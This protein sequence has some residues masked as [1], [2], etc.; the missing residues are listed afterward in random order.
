MWRLLNR[1]SIRTKF[2]AG[3]AL[4]FVW[5][6][7]LGGFAVDRLNAVEHAAAELRDGALQATVALSRIGQAAERLR[8]VQELLVT[9]VAEERRNTLMADHA[10]RA[11]D[12]QAAIELY[13]PTVTDGEE[14]GLAD[15]LVATW[16]AYGKLS[17]QLVAMTGQVQPDI[18]TGLL[19][20]RMLQAM[21]QFRDAQ[22]AAIDVGMATG[23]QAADRG[24][25]LG[26]VARRWILAAL[27]VSLAMCLCG[28]WLIIGDMARPIAAM[29]TA[30]RRLAQHDTNAAVVG[31]GRGDEIGMMADSV[32]QFRR[33]I[34][35][36]DRVAAERAAEQLA[37]A[38]H[39]EALET[40]VHGFEQQ[41]GELAGHLA[42]AA[43]T[44]QTTAG[45][46]SRSVGEASRETAS[47][48]A[49]AEQAR[50]N[51][52]AVAD[53]TDTLA[54]AIAEIGRQGTESA[55]IAGQAVADVQRTDRVVQALAAAARKIDEVLKLI[56][57]IAAQTNLLALN[58]TIEA[59]RAG[60]A[61]KGF[62]VVAS[63]VKS[64]AGQTARATEEIAGQVRQIQHTTAETVAA[65]QGIG[66]VVE[67]VGAIAASIAAAVEEQSAAT[68][69]IARNV[70]QAASG[71]SEVSA[72]IDQVSRT[73]ATAGASAEQVLA[74]ASQ[75]AGQADAL[76]EEMGQFGARFRAA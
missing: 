73:A 60:E 21:N 34:I 15:R 61:G 63:E 49:A 10:T 39:A 69:E 4:A 28:G 70:Q 25:A 72:S 41:I 56:G 66:A 19:N 75:V 9:A 7:G 62:A 11:K 58:A 76:S 30:M 71:T 47:V 35:E 54:S 2:I 26:R 43:C 24:E 68:V 31:L 17:S 40:L 37:K 48:A 46:M 22:H 50:A 8:S 3:F 52:Q 20:G 42:G 36:A 55:R 13:L 38:G 59:A 18:Q 53:A 12:V 51:V 16:A 33:G 67:H 23:R 5:T 44:L 27:G 32:E 74:A 1:I 45:S 29:S 14:H 65:V 57:D 6:V 64:L